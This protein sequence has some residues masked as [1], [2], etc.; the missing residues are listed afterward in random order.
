MTPSPKQQVEILVTDLQPP[1]V[2]QLIQLGGGFSNPKPLLIHAPR[3]SS[4]SFRLE[5]HLP[6]V[7]VH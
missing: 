5:H 3:S 2:L 4:H 6:S 7:F 1:N